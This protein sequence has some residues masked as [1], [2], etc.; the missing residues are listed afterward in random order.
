MRHVCLTWFTRW[1]VRVSPKMRWIRITIMMH[2]LRSGLHYYLIRWICKLFCFDYVYIEQR[3]KLS[4]YFALHKG[5]ASVSRR[6]IIIT[7]A[8]WKFT[9]SGGC[10][11]THDGYNG[12]R[13]NR[14]RTICRWIRW[15][16]SGHRLGVDCVGN[17]WSI[18]E[19]WRY[20]SR[21][22]LFKPVFR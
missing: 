15:R 20:R 16:W 12:A 11:H 9:R 18:M 22:E 8:E 19:F 13:K 17:D 7:D 3:Y 1:R 10:G 21:K 4:C 14:I 5:A 6:L 2:F